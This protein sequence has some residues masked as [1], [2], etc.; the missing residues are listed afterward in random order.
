MR[1]A[2]CGAT[3]LLGSTLAPFLR[4]QGYKVLTHSRG[5][6]AEYRADLSDATATCD[7][8]DKLAPDLV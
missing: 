1:I 4:A 6:G 5:E 2:I 7:L 8:M 3:G